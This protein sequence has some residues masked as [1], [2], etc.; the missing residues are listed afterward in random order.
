MNLDFLLESLYK[1]LITIGITTL[2]SVERENHSHPG[3]VVTH[4]LVGLGACLYTLVS[5]NMGTGAD[6]SRIAAQI[7]SGMGFLGSAT[8]IK[9]DTFVK[10]INTAAN[11]WVAAG[12]G[13]SVGMGMYEMPII[14]GVFIPIILYVSNKIYKL[15]RK[16]EKKRKKK[17]NEEIQGKMKR[18][19]SVNEQV[20]VHIQKEIDEQLQEEMDRDNNFDF[21]D[22]H[23]E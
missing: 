5:I 4:I 22:Y 7:V 11:L 18:M 23:V 6:P 12:I 19:E 9:S 3:G 21:I 8:V 17:V 16:K 14:L 15:K 2:I 10:G 13:L 20:K 1:S